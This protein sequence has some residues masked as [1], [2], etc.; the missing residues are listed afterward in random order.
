M[1]LPPGLYENESLASDGNNT[2]S[3][4]YQV[5]NHNGIADKF[6]PYVLH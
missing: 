6:S 4:S 1:N 5:N 3:N 2:N